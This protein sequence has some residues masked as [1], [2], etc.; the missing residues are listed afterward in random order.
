LRALID[1][2]AIIGRE[3]RGVSLREFDEWCVSA[4]TVGELAL[5]VAMSTDPD[6]RAIRRHTLINVEDDFSVREVD[7]RVAYTYGDLV[8]AAR[9]DG[10]RIAT[11]DA[12]IAATALVDN[13][14]LVT[15]DVDFLGVRGLEV[16]LV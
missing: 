4:I 14:P 13:I 12:F 1:T 5:G 15:Q 7:E 10:R 2:S 9:R 3:R 8:A 11:A 16:I 6:E